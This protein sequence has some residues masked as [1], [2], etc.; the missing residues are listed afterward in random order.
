MRLASVEALR[1][2]APENVNE[3]VRPRLADEDGAVR[4]RAAELLVQR[5]D[6]CAATWLVAELGRGDQYFSLPTGKLARYDA[7]FRLQALGLS[8]GVEFDAEQDP[9]GTAAAREAILA[10]V[11]STCG[12]L[13]E[14]P[15]TARPD[16]ARQ[17]DVLGLEL[18]SCRRGE[19]FL[20]WNSADMLFVGQGGAAAVQLPEGTVA[21]LTQALEGALAEL[22]DENFWGQPGCDLERI[23]FTRGGQVETLLISKGPEAQP[24]LRPDPLDGVLAGMLATLPESG[25][26]VR[27]VELRAR[28]QAA[29]RVLGGDPDSGEGN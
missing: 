26:D 4:R 17:G 19:F 13:P 7:W 14:L 18:R 3:L 5:G 22:G 23:H 15:P 16:Q 25:T 1:V 28:V 20:T 12:T 6:V 11:K 24:D 9:A 8:G 2:L 27:L 10:H 29:L 21:A